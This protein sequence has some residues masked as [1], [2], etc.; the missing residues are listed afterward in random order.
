M[1]KIADRLGIFLGL[2]ISGTLLLLSIVLFYR[3]AERG[4][5]GWMLTGMTFGI[6][7]LM[8]EGWY[9]VCAMRALLRADIPI[10]LYMASVQPRW[11]G[12]LGVL[13]GLWWLGHFMFGLMLAIGLTIERND[14]NA[15]TSLL[16]FAFSAGLTYISYGYALLALTAIARRADWLWWLWKQRIWWSA[17]HGLLYMAAIIFSLLE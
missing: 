4:L 15:L 14:V 2:M 11:P 7:V 12:G 1:R 5:A 17:G 16:G 8:T 13:V 6:W 10:P 3:S 9:F